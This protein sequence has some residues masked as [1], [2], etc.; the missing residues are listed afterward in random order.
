MSRIFFNLGD[1]DIHLS[2]PPEFLPL[3]FNG[4]P[5][6]NKTQCQVLLDSD[7]TI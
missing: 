7:L 3:L 6:M 5:H 1:V 4:D 2:N